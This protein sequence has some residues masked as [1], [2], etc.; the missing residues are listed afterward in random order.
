MI[1]K[2][3]Q[4]L[5]TLAL[6]ALAAGCGG[7]SSGGSDLAGTPGA[8]GTGGDPNQ[9]TGVGGSG[10]VAGPAQGF[11]SILINGRT[12]DTDDAEIL[13][14]GAAGTL[15][16]LRTGQQ[17]IVL[18]DLDE[19]VA[20]QVQYRASV[21]GPLTEL[22]VVDPLAR[23]ASA[24]VLGQPVELYGLTFYE[25]TRLADLALGDLLEVSAAVDAN[26]TLVATYLA[27]RPGLTSY[28]VLGRVTALDTAA[29]TFR[30]NG[31]TVDY[32]AATLADFTAAAPANGDLVEVVLAPADF[33]APGS[34][35]AQTVTRLPELA[36]NDDARVEIQGFID[37]FTSAG[38][39]EINGIAV[40]TDAGTVF[41]DGDGD[42]LGLNERVEVEGSFSNG[43]IRADR[44]LFKPLDT[45][46]VDGEVTAVDAA[47]GTVT[48]L[49]L[50]FE[51]R[52]LTELEDD[53]QDLDPFTLDQL[54]PGDWVELQGFAD[55]DVLVVTELE[56]ESPDGGARL[57]APVTAFDG[58]AQSLELLNLAIASDPVTTA[59]LDDDEP[60][61]AA[62]FFAALASGDL[63]E[64]RWASF[65]AAQPVSAQP[66]SELSLDDDE[67]DD[68]DDD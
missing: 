16:D 31:L 9:D 18:A 7:G 51:V 54:Q 4:T 49:E 21:R 24:T 1:P 32:G 64:A 17:L 52:A 55:S 2:L 27:A 67:D 40:T 47:A 10:L 57:V 53:L 22:T 26:G 25:G 41:V 23:R 43:V 30:L 14:D 36:L 38:D 11:G 3:Y 34:A 48:V 42:G 35:L 60:L 8:P 37:A 29:A 33:T 66:A 19:D 6:A 28:S 58:A 68:D 5:L 13:V 50:T 59:F 46:Q 12:L 44:V 45:V 62:A 63:V 56:R 39:F 61:D 15:G 65:D 20:E